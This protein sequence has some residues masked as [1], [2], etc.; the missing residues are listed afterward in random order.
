[1]TQNLIF[2]ENL[3][4]LKHDFEEESQLVMDPTAV[5]QSAKKLFN[6]NFYAKSELM[7]D[8]INNAK[9]F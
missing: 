8:D 2:N 5:G 6:R 9:K 4:S 7:L 1:M 3:Y